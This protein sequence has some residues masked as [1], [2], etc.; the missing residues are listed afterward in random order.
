MEQDVYADEGIEWNP[1]DFPDNQVCLNLIE[2]RP[3]GK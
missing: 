3:K 2:K 1:T